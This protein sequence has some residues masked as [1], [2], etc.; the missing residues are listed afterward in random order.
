[1]D[2]KLGLDW[3]INFEGMVGCLSTPNVATSACW[4]LS[5][6]SS[7][8]WLA[9]RNFHFAKLG[10][11]LREGEGGGGG[12]EMACKG[13]KGAKDNREVGRQ[14]SRQFPRAAFSETY[15]SSSSSSF[16]LR[17]RPR[18]LYVW[19]RLRATLLVDRFP[20]ENLFFLLFFLN[21]R[22]LKLELAEL[23]AVL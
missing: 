17:F 4:W 9:Y 23:Y 20:R 3:L 6:V 11:D 22:P 5:K 10:K 12:G 8:R 13:R 7:R 2:G 18:L 16:S 14:C 1:M 21:Y 19:P 15:F